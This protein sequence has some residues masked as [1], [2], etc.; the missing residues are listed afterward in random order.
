[1]KALFNKN[2]DV[3]TNFSKFI[4]YRYLNLKIKCNIFCMC[5]YSHIY[6]F[7]KNVISLIT[8]QNIKLQIFNFSI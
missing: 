5:T 1:M 2:S 3:L 4:T 6:I 8:I 7:R